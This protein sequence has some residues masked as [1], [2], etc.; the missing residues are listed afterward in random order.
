LALNGDLFDN[1]GAFFGA[2]PLADHP[3][4]KVNSFSS[5]SS[6]SSSSSSS[7]GGGS[8][9]GVRASSGG[10]PLAAMAGGWQVRPVEEW[11]IEAAVTPEVPDANPLSCAR[12]SLLLLRF[13]S[14][15]TLVLPSTSA[16]QRNKTL[17]FDPVC[18]L[19]FSPSM[20]CNSWC[21]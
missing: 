3:P 4:P 17:V 21:R 13:I 19:F 10:G 16:L 1:F 15:D 8:G 6:S 20:G 2:G 7:S 9:A 5:N 18:K 14:P 11:A 12:Y